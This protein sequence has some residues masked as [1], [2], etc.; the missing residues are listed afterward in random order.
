MLIVAPGE[1][2]LEPLN[3]LGITLNFAIQLFDL[4]I[5]ELQ[6]LCQTVLSFLKVID[7]CLLVHD[8]LMVLV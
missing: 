8:L 3:L 5:L 1:L 6:I 7:H 4:R 2:I